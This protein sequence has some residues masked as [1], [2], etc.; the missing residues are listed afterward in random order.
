MTLDEYVRSIGHLPF[1]YG[2]HD[3]TTF[4]CGW[5]KAYTGRDIQ[6]SLPKW[7]SF[8]SAQRVIGELGS[9]PDAAKVLLGEPTSVPKTG[10]IAF[11]GAPHNCFGI[12]NGSG[13]MV[14]TQQGLNFVGLS[15]AEFLWEVK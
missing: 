5:I 7:H 4:V 3:C 10:D 6:A 1:S 12:V 8:R 15:M 9:L 2:E 13:I 11:L 14:V